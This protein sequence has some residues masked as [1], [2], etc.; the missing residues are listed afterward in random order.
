MQ[1]RAMVM[2]HDT[3]SPDANSSVWGQVSGE[4]PNARITSSADAHR[5]WREAT[6]DVA[7]RIK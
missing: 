2:K 4:D 5:R 7:P 1:V 3:A 6:L